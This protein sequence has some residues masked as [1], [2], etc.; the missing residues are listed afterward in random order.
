MIDLLLVLTGLG[1]MSYVVEWLFLS[2]VGVLAALLPRT[3]LH[4]GK[5]GVCNDYHILGCIQLIIEVT[6]T[7]HVM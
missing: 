5:E 3:L 1:R 4:E 7:L 6:C 2:T